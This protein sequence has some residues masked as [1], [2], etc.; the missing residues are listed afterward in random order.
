MTSPSLRLC[1]VGALL[2]TCLAA[3]PGC[4]LYF[5]GAP[6]PRCVADPRRSPLG[7]AIDYLEATQVH[8][9]VRAFPGGG[10]WPGNWPQYFRLPSG[11]RVREVSPFIPAFIHASLGP[12]EEAAR[13]G[14]GDLGPR[15]AERV[16]AMR[17]RAAA[18]MRR[19]C[20]PA[21]GQ[22][23]GSVAFW[24][25]VSEQRAHARPILSA[26]RGDW[27]VRLAALVLLR[28]P[29]PRG[30]TLPLNAPQVPRRFAIAPDADDTAVVWA[31]LR[32]QAEADGAPVPGPPLGLFSAWRD[33][34]QVPLR[35]PAAWLE[36]PSG[37]FLTLFDGGINDLDLAANANV[38]YLLARCGRLDLPGAAEAT[39]TLNR[40]AGRLVSKNPA[41]PAAPYYPRGFAAHYFVARAFAQGPVPALR[42]AAELLAADVERSA[43]IATDGS[44]RWDRGS[45]DL[46]TALALLTLLHCGR[47]PELARA[48]ARRLLATQS[49]ATGAWEAGDFFQFRTDAGVPIRW[50]S[51][52]L[53]TALA[54][55]A[56]VRSWDGD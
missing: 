25:H 6:P 20:A 11:M 26:L 32:D 15:D 18:F 40:H 17:A 22:F 33:L 37:L 14:R 1:A 45:P 21:G 5:Y 50:R 28:G 55:E 49:R 4:G 43:R 51:A 13:Q 35:F 30:S 36:R 38:L 54:A 46:D 41:D 3:L 24:P 9:V 53:T 23:E 56:I 12:A 34:G 16:R 29:S 10:D 52:A 19:F 8:E 48:G 27:L 39:A 42:P 47:S 2:L 7:R 31:A 44:A